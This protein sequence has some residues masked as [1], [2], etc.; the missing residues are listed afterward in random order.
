[1][2]ET[3]SHYKL[4][5]LYFTQLNPMYKLSLNLAKERQ[6][7]SSTTRT[8]YYAW[9]KLHLRSSA[10]LASCSYCFRNISLYSSCNIPWSENPHQTL[11][12]RKN[13]PSDNFRL[14]CFPDFLVI[15]WYYHHFRDIFMVT[16]HIMALLA[17]V[18][19]MVCFLS[20]L[21][22]FSSGK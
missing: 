8:L 17:Y 16:H 4:F 7:Y 18:F 21:V 12:L 5:K 3:S 22:K 10:T 19:V 1:M 11:V 15:L 13:A 20:K 14:F 2:D 6:F 9:I